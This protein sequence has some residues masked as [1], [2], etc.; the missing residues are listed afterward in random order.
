MLTPSS[1]TRSW[2]SIARFGASSSTPLPL[3]FFS[4]FTKVA[5]DESK[6]FTLLLSRLTALSTP[7]GSLPIHAALWESATHTAH[8]FRARLA[9][10]HLVHE[11]RGLDVNPSTIAKFAR[12][13]D[14]ESV[15]ALEV[16]H[17]DE[18][19]HVTAGHRWFTWVCGQE[20]EGAGVDP[21]QA[22][23]EEV[24]R[25]FV[26]KLRGP[27]NEEDR[28]KAGLTREF[29]EDLEGERDKQPEQVDAGV[30]VEYEGTK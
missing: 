17:A 23:R 30:K 11:A 3:Q 15:K 27:F 22:F 20:N 2:D 1:Q 28:A 16:I 26:G 4:D 14:T 24:R 18:V 19:T 12:S 10:V 7:Y 5:L 8:S 13:G 21:V 29:Y 6:H 25:H 9:I